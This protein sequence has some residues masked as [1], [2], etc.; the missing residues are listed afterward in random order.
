MVVSGEVFLLLAE[1]E[2]GLDQVEEDLGIYYDTPLHVRYANASFF[3][4][5]KVI[6]L[7]LVLI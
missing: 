5:E 7:F 4:F 1:E 2:V 3:V 6:D